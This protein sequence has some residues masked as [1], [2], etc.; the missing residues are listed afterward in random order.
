MGKRGHKEGKYEY[1]VH[2]PMRSLEPWNKGGGERKGGVS[3]DRG[4]DQIY[5]MK[6]SSDLFN[7]FITQRFL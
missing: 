1:Y 3:K 4:T 5:S 6:V 7:I 2:L